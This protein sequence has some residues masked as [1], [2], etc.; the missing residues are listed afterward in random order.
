M[1]N[2]VKQP[3]KLPTNKLTVGLLVQYASE[4]IWTNIMNDLYPPLAGN[5]TGALVGLGIGFAVAYFVKDRANVVL[6]H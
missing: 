3:S 4:E 5:Y 2:L 6:E 1:T